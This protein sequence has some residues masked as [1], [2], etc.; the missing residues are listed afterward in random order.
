MAA[1]NIRWAIPPQTGGLLKTLL[2]RVFRIDNLMN[3][4]GD[5][6]IKGSPKSL[7]AEQIEKTIN[8]LI[9]QDLQ[10]LT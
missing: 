2:A 10:Q 4:Y 9:L 1:Q 8:C 6:F 5:V 3:D 7:W